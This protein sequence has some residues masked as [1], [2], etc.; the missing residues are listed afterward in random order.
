MPDD[1]LDSDNIL[2]TP[3]SPVLFTCV[4]PQS[5]VDIL[6]KLSTLTSSSYFS[7][8]NAIAPSAIASSLFII[9]VLDGIFFSIL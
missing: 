2:N 4:P 1:I 5:S 3:I 9:L 8:N 7:P 6:P